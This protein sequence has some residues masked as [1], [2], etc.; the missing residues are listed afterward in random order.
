MI[1]H[2]G[3]CRRLDLLR[4]SIYQPID[5]LN[6]HKAC[7][8]WTSHYGY[9]QVVAFTNMFWSSSW[10]DVVVFHHLSKFVPQAEY[11]FH[12]LIMVWTSECE[13]HSW[14]MQASTL[15][16]VAFLQR[17]QHSVGFRWTI[18]SSLPGHVLQHNLGV[19]FAGSCVRTQHTVLDDA[20]SLGIPIFG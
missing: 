5:C 19:N 20:C 6:H 8:E 7:R 13:C 11:L 4:H 15:G 1:H 18:L 3:Q 14:H 16:C 10:C 9:I 17:I 2:A 12:V